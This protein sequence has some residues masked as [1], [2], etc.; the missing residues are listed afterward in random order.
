MFESI[1][2]VL[3]DVDAGSVCSAIPPEIIKLL[4]MVVLFIQIGV[5]I[6]LIVFGMVDLG[7][8]VMQQK[9]D[10]IKEAQQMFIKRLIA[11]ALVFF[12]IVIIGFFLSILEVVL[13]ESQMEGI[14]TCVKEV[15]PSWFNGGGGT[16]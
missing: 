7:K 16:P 10:D 15:F 8:A 1:F 5:P 13:G 14:L 9:E 2:M 12:I 11:A 3:A 6:I 4:Q